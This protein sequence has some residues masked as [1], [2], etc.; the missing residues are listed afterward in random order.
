[1][2]KR[3][4][5]LTVTYEIEDGYAGGARPQHVEIDHSE[6]QNCDDLEAAVK[7]VEEYIQEDFTQKAYPTYDE[8]ELRSAIEEVFNQRPQE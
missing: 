3:T 5:R 6:I 7:M 2:A 1:M 8:D 4:D